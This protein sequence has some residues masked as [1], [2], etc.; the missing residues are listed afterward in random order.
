MTATEEYSEGNRAADL[1]VVRCLIGILVHQ[2]MSLSDPT[3]RSTA[4]AFIER[5]RRA[6]IDYGDAPYSRNVRYEL[7]VHTLDQSEQVDAPIEMRTDYVCYLLSEAMPWTRIP[8]DVVRNAVSLWPE[9]K[10]KESRLCALRELARTLGCDAPS[11]PTMI[12]QARGRV[13]KRPE[14]ARRK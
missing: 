7:I 3:S 9:R 14:A 6:L 13:Q 5:A 10:Q 2:G 1:A 11:L 12:R 8:R 4:R